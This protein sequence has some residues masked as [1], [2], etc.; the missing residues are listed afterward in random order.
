MPV[1]LSNAYCL[2]YGQGAVSQVTDLE[3]EVAELRQRLARVSANAN[4]IPAAGTKNNAAAIA[5]SKS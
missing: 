5:S 4:N 2:L 1:C 3:R